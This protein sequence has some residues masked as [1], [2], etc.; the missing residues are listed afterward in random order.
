MISGRPAVTPE[1]P[2]TSFEDLMK[3]AR[4]THVH[5][6]FRVVLV[7]EYSRR[8]EERDAMIGQLQR[9]KAGVCQNSEGLKRQLE[10]E[11]KVTLNPNNS[12]PSFQFCARWV[13]QLCLHPI[14]C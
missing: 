3:E 5:L 2:E 13:S 6:L 11:S 9:S 10:E 7:A 1:P 8:L 12:H 14:S 4:L